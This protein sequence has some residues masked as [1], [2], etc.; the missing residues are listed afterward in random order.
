[1]VISRLTRHR[2]LGFLDS[3]SARSHARPRRRVA[4]SQALLCSAP[5]WP[6]LSLPPLRLDPTSPRPCLARAIGEG[7]SSRRRRRLEVAP[8]LARTVAARCAA[9]PPGAFLPCSAL[10]PPLATP[11]RARRAGFPARIAHAVVSPSFPCSGATPRTRRHGHH[12]N[13]G[14]AKAVPCHSSDPALPPTLLPECATILA[15]LVQPRRRSALAIAAWK[16]RPCERPL[17]GF[18]N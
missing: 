6:A 9:P 11:P 5:S 16:H 4:A 14:S 10:D 13:P 3:T 1:M 17:F 12:R 18:G 8:P 2:G 15:D 7:R